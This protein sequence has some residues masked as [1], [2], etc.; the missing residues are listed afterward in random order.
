M[1]SSPTS[2][3]Y[4][5]GTD[6]FV[7]EYSGSG[8]VTA[9]LQAVDLVLPPGPRRARPPAA[10]SPRTSPT[11]RTG[12]IAL[13]QRGTCDFSVKA[14]NASDAGAAASSSSTRARRD[15]HE[16]LNPTLGDQ[17]SDRLPGVGTSFADRQRPRRA[18]RRRG[19]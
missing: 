1:S 14:Q 4:V 6:Y 18:P 17:F 3:R 15:A 19:P 7:A 2:P 13:V 16:T 9:R 10:A 5:E 11:S 12:N 8:D